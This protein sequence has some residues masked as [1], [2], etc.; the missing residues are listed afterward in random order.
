MALLWTCGIQAHAQNTLPTLGL[1]S[2]SQEAN[3]FQNPTFESGTDGWELV[4]FA[5][6]ESMEVDTAEVHNG[7]PS[8]R[9]TT[10]AGGFAFVR[11]QIGKPHTHYR[12]SGYIKTKNVES[13]H[14]D[15]KQGA[16]L[17]VGFTANVQG[18]TTVAL[19]KSKSW[20]KVTVDFTSS[21]KAPFAVGL[22][23]GSYNANVIGTAWFSEP[24]LVEIGSG[25]KR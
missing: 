4:A 16:C 8:L 17:M 1:K 7:K 6:T 21:D 13:V 5:K 10:G 12:L 24:S 20:T 18:G 19:Q 15:G 22:G 9:V 2:A 11:Q 3:L 25:S 23:L 14:R